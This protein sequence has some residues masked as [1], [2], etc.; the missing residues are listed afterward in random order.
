MHIGTRIEPNINHN[1]LG[2]NSD[3]RL[4]EYHFAPVLLSIGLGIQKIWASEHAEN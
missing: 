4:K 2:T 3:T 1:A